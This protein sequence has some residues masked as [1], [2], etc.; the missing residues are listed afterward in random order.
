M[1]IK[2]TSKHYG[3]ITKFLHWSIALLIFF[4]FYLVYWKRNYLPENSEIAKFYINDLHK[5][6]GILILILAILAILWKL[7]NIKPHFPFGMSRYEKFAAN[8]VHLLLYLTLIIMPLS[9]LLMTVAGGR[10]PNFFGL[11]QI[12]QFMNVNKD[13]SEVF[14]HLHEITGVIIVVLV[15]IH[16]LAALKHHFI[17]HD[18]VLKRML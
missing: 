2:N 5:P 1:F 4:Q 15:A 18:T 16:V 14:W 6:I 8:N 7:I 9:G 3:I 11:Y 13:L 17:D 12:P 10:P